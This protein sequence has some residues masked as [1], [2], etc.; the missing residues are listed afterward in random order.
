MNDE[1]GVGCRQVSHSTHGSARDLHRHTPVAP[2]RLYRSYTSAIVRLTTVQESGNDMAT[3]GTT[4]EYGRDASGR[5]WPAFMTHAELVEELETAT[6]TRREALR[7][8]A[9]SR[10]RIRTYPPFPGRLGLGSPE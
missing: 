4:G 9:K 3:T 2:L 10:M 5:H 8:E 1:V 7:T 6:G